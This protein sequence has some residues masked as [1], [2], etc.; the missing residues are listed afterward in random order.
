MPYFDLFNEAM[1]SLQ[2][3]IASATGLI[4][5][6]DPEKINP[7]CVLMNAPTWEAINWNVVRIDVP[8]QVIAQGVG[9][10]YS[11]QSVLSMCASILGMK[12]GVKDGRPNIIDVGGTQMPCYDITISVEAST[13]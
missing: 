10:I 12:S 2:F 4:V 5:V 1:E 13:K 9:D 8:I 3:Q 6:M 11:L 7:P